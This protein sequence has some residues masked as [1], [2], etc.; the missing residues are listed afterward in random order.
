[1]ETLASLFP[2]DPVLLQRQLV[3]QVLAGNGWLASC[4]REVTDEV[5]AAMA[6]RLPEALDQ[7][8]DGLIST[9]FRAQPPPLSVVESLASPSAA[10]SERGSEEA[11]EL[12]LPLQRLQSRHEPRLQ[13][14]V[15]G[16]PM[17]EAVFVVSL[18]L[19][20]RNFR[21]RL[22][23]GRPGALRTGSA[24]C[25]GILMLGSQMLARFS[26]Q[27]LLLPAVLRLDL[28]PSARIA[29]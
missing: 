9:A 24:S 10:G 22:R 28:P 17:L 25:S 29:P 23:D 2:L 4:G 14:Q 3:G 7:R 19:M 21:L 5:A 27:P 15:D 8:L 1:M 11:G 6:Q 12:F 20:L 16:R 26:D 18:E 13:L